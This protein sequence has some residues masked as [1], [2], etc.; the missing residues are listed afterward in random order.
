MPIETDNEA[1]ER[2]GLDLSGKGGEKKLAIR[3]LGLNG[4]NAEERSCENYTKYWCGPKF[5]IGYDQESARGDKRIEWPHSIFFCYLSLNSNGTLKSSIYV[6]RWKNESESRQIDNGR[7]EGNS[8]E[9]A[10]FLRILAIHARSGRGGVKSFGATADRPAFEV[11]FIPGEINGDIDFLQ[12][13]SWCAYFVDVP[14]WEFLGIGHDKA[15]IKFHEIKEKTPFHNPKYAFTD[16]DLYNIGMPRDILGHKSPRECAVMIN[17]MHDQDNIPRTTESEIEKFSFDL[18]IR[19]Y[20]EYSSNGVTMLIDP[21]GDNPGP[22]AP[23][24][25]LG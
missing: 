3:D 2:L 25:V 15:A 6:M 5:P 19:V 12:R 14:Y 10:Y 22:P 23:P 20:F 11:E 24:P 7:G 17:R 8:S 13:Y 4:E 21:G 9:V 1:R 16:S 18:V